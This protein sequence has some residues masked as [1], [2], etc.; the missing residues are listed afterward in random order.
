MLLLNHCDVNVFRSY[1]ARSFQLKNRFG[2]PHGWLFLD[3][4]LLYP[5]FEIELGGVF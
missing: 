1:F 3:H 2:Q 4:I 5:R